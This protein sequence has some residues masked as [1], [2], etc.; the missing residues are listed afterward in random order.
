MRRRFR[1]KNLTIDVGERAEAPEDV[2]CLLDTQQCFGGTVLCRFPSP[3]PALSRRTLCHFLTRPDC[4][5]FT[6]L[7]F[8][9]PCGPHSPVVQGRAEFECPPP[10]LPRV[11][12]A[13]DVIDVM[14]ALRADL[15]QAAEE[16]DER[17][18]QMREAMEPST[19]E[20]LDAAEAELEAALERVRELREQTGE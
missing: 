6:C 18:P 5:G 14:E 19:P 8:T 20:E 13:G 3:C 11:E 9:P 16:L 4:P 7:F 12:E 15:H 2:L 17:V 10:S 1:M